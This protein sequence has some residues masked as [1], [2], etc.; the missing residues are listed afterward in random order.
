[1][2]VLIVEDEALIRLI[3]SEEFVEAGFE[4][5]EAVSGDEAV[6]LIQNP[7]IAF[8]L[9]VT[10]IHMPGKHDGIAVARLM[11]RH[12]PLVPVIYI[13]GRPDILNSIGPLGQTEALLAKP[14]LPSR[15]LREAHRLLAQ[16]TGHREH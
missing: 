1:L 11:R 14:F 6:A 9:L 7:P 12:Y 3:V 15:L 5:R 2:C 10:D 8:T 4:V 13:S 16:G